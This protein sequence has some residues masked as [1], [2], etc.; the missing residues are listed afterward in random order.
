LKP[1]A[2]VTKALDNVIAAKS[3]TI[4]NTA[5]ANTSKALASVLPV[6]QVKENDDTTTALIRFAVSTL[7]TDIQVYC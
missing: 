1:E 7:Q 6:I 4:D 2:F 3:V 5:K